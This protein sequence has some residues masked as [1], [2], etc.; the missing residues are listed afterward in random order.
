MHSIKFSATG[1]WKYVPHG[2]CPRHHLVT[3][4]VGG[5]E[6]VVVE[7]EQRGDDAGAARS[8]PQRIGILRGDDAERA[9]LRK[10]ATDELG[11]LHRVIEKLN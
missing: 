9:R 4:N 7:Q 3:G 11:A 6:A 1:F 10:V 8:R 5:A 2:R